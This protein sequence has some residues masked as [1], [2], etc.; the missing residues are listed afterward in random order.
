MMT[1]AE[2]YRLPV[3]LNG[4]ILQQIITARLPEIASAKQKLPAESIRMV[5]DR[6]PQVRSLKRALRRRPGILAEI[7]RASPSAGLLC[8]NLDPAAIAGQYQKGGAAAISVVTEA[9]YFRG[10]LEILAALRWHTDLP[11]LRKDFI[12]DSYQVLESRHAGAD[13]VLLITALLERSLLRELRICAEELGMDAL[14]EVHNEG[15]MGRALEAGST[16]IGVNSR[17]L[18]SFD[19]ALDICARLAAGLPGEVT[20]VAESGIRTVGDIR[21][22]AKA[23][24][25]G[26]LI[27]EALMR[28]ASPQA[29]LAE[30]VSALEKG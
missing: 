19:V 5:L 7:K 18:R 23:G 27:G 10:G 12:V 29:K 20:A 25:R 14:V 4:T 3:E 16:L 2:K 17:D 1:A 22:L 28:A 11:L 24:Y 26:F 9:N 8:P 21:S 15:E 6:A 13:A 30:F